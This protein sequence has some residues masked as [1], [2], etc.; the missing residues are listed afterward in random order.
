M[1]REAGF[2]SVVIPCYNHGAYL[3]ESLQSILG[4]TF[5]N[6][7]IIIVDDGSDDP[8]TLKALD[9]LDHPK[10]NVLRKA[11]GH[12]SSARNHGIKH[13]NGEYILTLDA[14]DQFMPDFL[15]RA[16]AILQKRSEIGVVTCYAHVYDSLGNTAAHHKTGG[17]VLNFLAF[18]NSM[19]S[20]LFRFRCW[21]DA[22]GFNEE[23]NGKTKGFEDWDF[24]LSVTRAGWVIHSIPE[25]LIRYR[26]T[27]DSMSAGYADEVPMMKKKLVLRHEEV[28]RENVADVLYQK[29]QLICRLKNDVEACKSSITY[30]LGHTL[31]FPM[32]PLWSKLTRGRKSL[33]KKP[34]A[35]IQK[36][37]AELCR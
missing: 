37:E 18:N 16:T 13:S 9:D 35:N 7:E 33:Q 10:V 27:P 8:Q 26:K 17:T 23:Y 3:Q 24:W 2:V 32:K 11:N 34:N 31:L 22:R 28:Y 15:E 25:N 36:Q 4:Q 5:K 30:R 19:A 29:E 12:V 6:Y 14:D 1:A 21:E 20:A